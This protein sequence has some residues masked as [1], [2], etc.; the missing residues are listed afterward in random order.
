MDIS[1]SFHMTESE[2]HRGKC[3]PQGHPASVGRAGIQTQVG[4]L[5]KP[6]LITCH[7]HGLIHEDMGRL[8]PSKVAREPEEEVIL[9]ATKHDLASHLGPGDLP[10]ILLCLAPSSQ[11]WSSTLTAPHPAWEAA[12][13]SPLGQESRWG[14]N[15]SLKPGVQDTR[16]V[17]RKGRKPRTQEKVSHHRL[18]T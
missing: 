7:F 11:F 13:G 18:A 3:F 9:L 6:A 8:L 15:C 16:E 2:V 12:T 4:L 14:G 10:H 17:T 5:L 1:L